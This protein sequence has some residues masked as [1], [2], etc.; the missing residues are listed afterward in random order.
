MGLDDGPQ[1]AQ[2]PPRHLVEAQEGKAFPECRVVPVS[3]GVRE[4][5]APAVIWSRSSSPP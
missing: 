5:T 1:C 4:W 2:F 3:D